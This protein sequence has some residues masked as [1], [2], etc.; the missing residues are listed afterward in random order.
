MVPGTI[1]FVL[2]QVKRKQRV[3]GKTQKIG[4]IGVMYGARKQRKNTL[5]GILNYANHNS[6]ALKLHQEEIRKRRDIQTVKA[7]QKEEVSGNRHTVE[8]IKQLEL[9]VVWLLFC[10]YYK[11]L[12]IKECFQSFSIEIIAISRGHLKHP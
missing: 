12:A 11:P 5:L 8:P 9:P 1:L 6:R 2:C 7:K 10:S 3:F 4:E